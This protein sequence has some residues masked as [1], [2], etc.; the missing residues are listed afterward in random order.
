MYLNYG[1]VTLDPIVESPQLNFT[2]RH[3]HGGDGDSLDDHG[4]LSEIAKLEL[5]RLKQSYPEVFS[6]PQYPVDR[7]MCQ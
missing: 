4:S 3:A 5:Q 2:H 7:S 6:E 1:L